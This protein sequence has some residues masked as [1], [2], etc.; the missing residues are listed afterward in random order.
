MNTTEDARGR[1]EIKIKKYATEK[2]K[3]P[4][5]STAMKLFFSAFSAVFHQSQLLRK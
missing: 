2:T 4:Q 3:F 5:D 1:G